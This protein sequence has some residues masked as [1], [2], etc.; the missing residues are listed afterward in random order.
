MTSKKRKN[1]NTISQFKD[2]YPRVIWCHVSSFL[3]LAEDITLHDAFYFPIP[4]F[5]IPNANQK[6]SIQDLPN[7]SFGR[8]GGQYNK[9]TERKC[10]S[11][12]LTQGLS[13]KLVF[14]LPDGRCQLNVG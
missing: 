2:R 8:N 9:I 3:I 5:L 12:M 14:L 13:D 7:S 10:E 1:R 11:K 6:I 4:R